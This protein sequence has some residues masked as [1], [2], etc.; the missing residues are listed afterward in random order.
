MQRMEY[1]RAGPYGC[2]R[3]HTCADSNEHGCRELETWTLFLGDNSLCHGVLHLY[4]EAAPG[5]VEE[6]CR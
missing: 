2:G 6:G 4:W 3:S 5:G 1:A